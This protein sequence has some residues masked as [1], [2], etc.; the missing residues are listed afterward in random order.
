MNITFNQAKREDVTTIYELIK[1]LA[2]Y[3]HMLN[4]V[5]GTIKQLEH[6]LFNEEKAHVI[7]VKDKDQAIG[8]A[9]YFYT[10]STF[11]C[12]PGMYL[13]DLFIIDKYR[14]KGIGHELIQY[15]ASICVEE[16]LQ[17]LEWSCL[18]W[19]E[20]SIQF[21]EQKLKANNQKEWLKYRLN[22][23]EI[24]QLAHKKRNQNE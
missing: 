17:R 1:Q 9:L 11:L 8:F 23:N 4:E 13:E 14:N 12:K 15:L 22:V 7:V 10:F 2:E 24:E 16:S 19:N 6:Y 21:Y 3:E 5:V 20:S 18:D